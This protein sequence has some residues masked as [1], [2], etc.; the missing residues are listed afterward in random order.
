MGVLQMVRDKMTGDDVG[1]LVGEIESTRSK[2]VVAHTELDRLEAARL[3]A[4]DYDAAKTIEARSDRVRFEVDKLAAALPLLENRLSIARAA[5]NRKLLA[6]HQDAVRRLLPRLVAAVTNAA[7]IQ[8]EAIADRE[9]AI[10]DLGEGAVAAAIEP[11]AYLG[12][13]TRPFV[14]IWADAMQKRLV[15]PA[16]QSAPV[17]VAK[18]V[19]AEPAAKPAPAAPVPSV[20]PAKPVKRREPRRDKVSVGGRL[21]TML[22]SGIEIDGVQCSAGDQVSVTMAQADSLLKAGAAELVKT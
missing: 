18:P 22:R 16:P 7:D 19:P 9:A 6:K 5:R 3:V 13:L 17:A 8:E 1:D 2:G 11:I 21:V 20:E 4:E 15:A 12:M 10:A 14:A